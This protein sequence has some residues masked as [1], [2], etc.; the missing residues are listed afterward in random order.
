M[1]I[2]A[3]GQQKKKNEKSLS[4]TGMVENSWSCS[5]FLTLARCKLLKTALHGESMSNRSE[6]PRRDTGGGRR[7]RGG[8]GLL[9]VVGNKHRGHL[10]HSSWGA[11]TTGTALKVPSDL[12]T[13]KLVPNSC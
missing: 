4:V 13:S 8:G 7:R 11:R 10:G 5:R 6:R 9:V 1:G 3:L 12:G 2:F